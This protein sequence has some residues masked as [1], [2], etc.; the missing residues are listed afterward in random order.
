[1]GGLT[2]SRNLSLNDA[3]SAAV[4]VSVGNNNSSTTYSGQLS[5]GGNLTK[6]GSG[7]L[8]LAGNSIYSG[9]TT[10]S[11][12]TLL[13]NNTTGSATG[14]GAVTVNGG[15]FGGTGAVSGPVTVNNS[16]TLSPGA[17]VA[18]LGTGALTFNTGSNLLYE[19]DSSAALNAGADLLNSSGALAIAPGVTLTLND[20]ATTP[21]S[22][23]VGSKFTMISYSGPWDGDTFNSVPDNSVLQVGGNYFYVNYDDTT[24]GTNFGGG[25]NNTFVTLTAVP[26]AN[27][28]W[29]GGALC[30]VLGLAVGTRKLIGGR[31][32]A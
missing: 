15:T 6:Q 25:T 3:S 2:G 24:G 12:G 20:V 17:S 28:F 4:A 27:A 8:I 14:S 21:G 32:A 22:V 26:E 10:V 16:G 31:T 11:A 29:L 30:L 18:A 5:G 9:G 23:P 7:T 13:A 1:M 19:I